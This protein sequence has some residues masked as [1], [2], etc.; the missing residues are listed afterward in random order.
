MC[1]RNH[2]RVLDN[3]HRRSIHEIHHSCFGPPAGCAAVHNNIKHPSCRAT[4]LS[5]GCGRCPGGSAARA[6]V[7][8]LGPGRAK[9]RESP[10]GPRISHRQGVGT[11]GT[12]CARGNCAGLLPGGGGQADRRQ[13]GQPGMVCVVAFPPR[14]ET[15]RATGRGPSRRLNRRLICSSRRGRCAA[16][17]G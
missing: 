11:V 1:N 2:D 13:T 6:V 8:P 5:A 4:R 14:L 7:S 17:V 12:R 9:H 15:C 16:V 3:V 10:R